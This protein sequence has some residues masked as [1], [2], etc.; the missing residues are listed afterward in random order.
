MPIQT[1][2]VMVT[3]SKKMLVTGVEM[4]QRVALTRAAPRVLAA[5]IDI[6]LL[7]CYGRE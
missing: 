2:A 6:W 1:I 3:K 4:N 7:D 5:E